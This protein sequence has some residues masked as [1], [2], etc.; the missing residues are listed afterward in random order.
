[1]TYTNML[2][3]VTILNIIMSSDGIPSTVIQSRGQ[4]LNKLICIRNLPVAQQ[5]YHWYNEKC[6][7]TN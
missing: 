5:K 6:R 3:F 4:K 1:M 2:Q 7:S